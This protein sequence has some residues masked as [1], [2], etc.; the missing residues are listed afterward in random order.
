MCTQA[1]EPQLLNT[2]SPR[3]MDV[4]ESPSSVQCLLCGCSVPGSGLALEHQGTRLGTTL[5]QLPSCRDLGKVLE[6][7]LLLARWGT[8]SVP[9]V[10]DTTL[11]SSS[12]GGRKRGL[13]P[14][15][16]CVWGQVPTLLGT[17]VSPAV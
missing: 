11:G 10:K 8:Y 16:L 3:V 2:L 12:L 17:S 4:R 7:L 15:Q 13:N 14:R 1:W 9:A 6:G 5:E